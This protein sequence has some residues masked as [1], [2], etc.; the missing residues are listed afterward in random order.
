[1]ETCLASWRNGYSTFYI[2]PRFWQSI[3]K[4]YSFG[5]F[6]AEPFWQRFSFLF[7]SFSLPLG[8]LL[9]SWRDLRCRP[10]SERSAASFESSARILPKFFFYGDSQ[11]QMNRPLRANLIY[12]I[13]VIDRK[14]WF[15]EKFD[16]NCLKETTGE[17]FS[18]WM[19]GLIVNHPKIEHY[20]LQI[21][22]VRIFFVQGSFTIE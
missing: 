17:I 13:H 10:E 12:L 19:L 4:R 14:K 7:L 20:N 6:F 22:Q 5:R 3:R 1:M 18:R 16:Q 11:C 9:V 15:I 21:I 8:C 2:L